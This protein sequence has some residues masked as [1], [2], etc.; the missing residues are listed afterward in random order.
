MFTLSPLFVFLIFNQIKRPVDVNTGFLLLQIKQV[1][2]D[3][4]V[5]K[6]L[7]GFAVAAFIDW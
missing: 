1:N 4:S 2:D 5:L 7:T 3:H 6:L